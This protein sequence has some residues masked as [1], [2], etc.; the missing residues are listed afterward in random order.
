MK[1]L[2]ILLGV[3]T[4]SLSSCLKDKPNVDLSNIGTFAELPHSGLPYFGSD[5]ITDG[6]DANGFVTRE[7][8]INIT[9]QYAPSSDVTVTLAVDNSLIDAYNAA[10]PAVLP[11]IP[12]TPIPAAAFSLSATTVTIKAG[13]RTAI[14]TAK[15]DKNKM[16]PAASYMVP[17]KIASASGNSVA[18]SANFNVH[19]FHFIGNDFAGPYTH[20]Y[21]RW[22]KPDTT[23]SAP[24]SYKVNKGT[25]IFN[26][27]SP[28][29]FTVA[30]FYYSQ[31]RY[32]VTFVK[33]GSGATATYSS[34]KVTFYGTD[35][36]DGFTANGLTLATGPFFL[37]ADYHTNP[38]NP[39]GVYTHA[40][41]LKLFRFFFTTG[42]RALIDE[43]VK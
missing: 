4:V 40:Q 22:E 25:S 23:T 43:Y 5:A 28:Q 35:I 31:P 24:S 29:E 18:L 37:P 14:V 41:A 7:F 30:A 38:F 33:T 13:T 15:F 16:D 32:D 17:V 10:N 8:Y 3:L 6:Q 26:P 1:K 39:N 34:F 27:I 36:A 12:Y 2:I 42:S 11:N 9:G 20:L 21:T 19:Y